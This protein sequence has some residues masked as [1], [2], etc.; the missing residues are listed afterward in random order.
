MKFLM[1]IVYGRFMIREDIDIYN[2]RGKVKKKIQKY[3]N[4]HNC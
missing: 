3:N 1:K 2:K 4:R